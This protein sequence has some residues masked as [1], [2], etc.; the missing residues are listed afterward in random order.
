P[1]ISNVFELSWDKVEFT[2]AEVEGSSHENTWVR[3]AVYR[4]DS[5]GA[6]NTAEEMQ[7]G[8]NLIAVTGDTTY[9]DIATPSSENEYHYFVTAV[10]RNSIESEASESVNVGMVVSNEETPE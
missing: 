6:P 1:E 2:G 8:S 9:T 7:K 5:D 10:S 4:V 3:Y